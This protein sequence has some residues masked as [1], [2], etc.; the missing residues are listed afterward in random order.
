MTKK[1][2]KISFEKFLAKYASEEWILLLKSYTTKHLHSKNERIFTEGEKV[3]GV[4]FINS[5]KV[6][7]VS[8]YDKDHERIMRLST[9]GDFLGHR[10]TL[11]VHYP[12]SAIA[13][14]SVETTFIPMEIYLKLIKTNPNFA[15]FIIDFLTKDLKNTEERMKSIIHND[16][17]VRLGIIICM[18]ID[19]FG[20]DEDVRQKLHY[21]LSRSDMAS[22]AGTTYE[23]VIRN[24][25]KLE[26]MKLIKLE[27]KN[28]HV[29]KEKEL[30]KLTTLK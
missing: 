22:F 1:I 12:I 27:N 9:N 15:L 4:Y 26:D 24:L 6:K 19:V 25:A 2:M 7:I 5:G 23:S 14:S 18:L 17:I 28:I 11:S 16:V 10:A 21:T 30:R 20:F 13:L 8:S 3:R 29:L